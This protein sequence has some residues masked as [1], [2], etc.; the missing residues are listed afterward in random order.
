[1]IGAIFAPKTFS[2]RCPVALHHL[3]EQ[4]QYGPGGSGPRQQVAALFVSTH[5]CQWS[6]APPMMPSN[7]TIPTVIKKT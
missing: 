6:T 5:Q 4:A 2:F 1:M 3:I 7:K